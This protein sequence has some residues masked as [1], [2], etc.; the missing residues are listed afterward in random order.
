[1][2]L[3]E[4]IYRAIYGGD[5][6]GGLTIVMIA[7][8]VIGGGWSAI[9]LG[10]LVAVPR[11]RRFAL[12]LTAAVILQAVLVFAMKYAVGR[13]R[14]WLALG[15]HPPIDAPP[16]DFS[17]PSGHASGSFT[18]AVFVATVCLSTRAI[19]GRRS[20]AI[21]ALALAF[22]IS[23]SRVYLGVHYPGDVSAGALLGSAI[24]FVAARV[25]CAKLRAHQ[26]APLRANGDA[27]L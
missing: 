14:P 5:V 23:F 21:V 6:A 3:D 11:T 24:G 20:F 4:R 25:Y 13:V 19:R 17:F 16:T 10:P 9:V 15:M 27:R 1:M 26:G 18:V 7:L 22:A 8:S 12:A 2:G